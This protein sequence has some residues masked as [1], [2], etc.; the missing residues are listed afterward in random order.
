MKIIPC[1]CYK[2]SPIL[3]LLYFSVAIL[4]LTS[5]AKKNAQEDSPTRITPLVIQKASLTAIGTELHASFD[6]TQF[7]SSAELTISYQWYR[8]DEFL[9]DA[10]DDVYIIQALDFVGT[11]R[12]EFKFKVFVELEDGTETQIISEPIII[13]WREPSLV[14][15]DSEPKPR[16]HGVPIDQIIKLQLSEALNAEAVEKDRIILSPLGSNEAEVNNDDNSVPIN[17][18]LAI[19]ASLSCVD[20][21]NC[22][23]IEIEPLQALEFGETYSVQ[24]KGL[25]LLID[26][27]Q[28]DSYISITTFTTSFIGVTSREFNLNSLNRYRRYSYQY[29]VTGLETD[30]PYL[31]LEKRFQYES[32]AT[33]SASGLRVYNSEELDVAPVRV[34]YDGGIEAEQTIKNYRYRIRVGEK[35]I[36]GVDFSDP[37]VDAKWGTS[38]DL[39]DDFYLGLNIE[40]SRSKLTEYYSPVADDKRMPEGE[41]L[42][43]DNLKSLVMAGSYGLRSAILQHIGKDELNR[44]RLIAYIRYGTNQQG[45]A[46]GENGAVD[47]DSYGLPAAGNDDNIIEY[48]VYTYDSETGVRRSR[49]E[50]SSVEIDQVLSFDPDQDAPTGFRRYVYADD[51]MLGT[52][53]NRLRLAEIAYKAAGEDGVWQNSTEHPQA[54]D[55]NIVRDI[56]LRFICR[57]PEKGWYP[58]YEIEI[59]LDNSGDS[60]FIGQQ[61]NIEE[62]LALHQS[63]LIKEDCDQINKPSQSIINAA[64][65]FTDQQELEDL[66][67]FTIY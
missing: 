10:N 38:D 35:L 2:Q 64:F 25:P 39:I 66:V 60:T 8:D 43:S 44:D 52:L 50:Y 37:G 61:K 13:V 6:H 19:P 53:S 36:G 12:R 4:A 57:H 65:G 29:Q 32:P 9:E 56:E 58:K 3:L 7:D 28:Q 62:F 55:D 51:E 34:T 11:D 40:A 5:C 20:K 31:S 47:L 46:Y 45:L 15:V 30:F 18:K 59:D 49:T 26:N 48:Q 14:I 16:A 17:N 21:N 24:V 23:A 27:I 22:I 63:E 41:S 42:N 1:L 67:A 33:S 54:E